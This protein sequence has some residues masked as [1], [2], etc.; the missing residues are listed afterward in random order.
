M[1]TQW[2]IYGL[3]WLLPTLRTEAK[4]LYLLSGRGAFYMFIGTLLMAKYPSIYDFSFGLYMGTLGFFMIVVGHHAQGKISAMKDHITDVDMLTDKFK[5]WDVEGTGAL[6]GDE[7]ASLCK[8]LGCGL[9]K[10]EIA[11]ALTCLDKNGNGVVEYGEFRAWWTAVSRPTLLSE[12]RET[13]AAVEL[14]VDAGLV[15]QAH[16]SKAEKKRVAAEKKAAE[17]LAEK[18]RHEQ[19]QAS[20]AAAADFPNGGKIHHHSQL[21]EREAAKGKKM[22]VNEGDY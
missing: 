9:D 16:Q 15:E 7:L 21:F 20:N 17:Y 8:E 12:V 1:E 11:T 5:K 19:A 22:H 18:E 2:Q 13:V 14:H 10:N 3:K 6:T 4:F